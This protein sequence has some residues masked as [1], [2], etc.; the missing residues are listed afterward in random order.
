MA[1]WMVKRGL[2]FDCDDKTEIAG[3]KSVVRVYAQ[4]EIEQIIRTNLHTR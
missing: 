1:K 3:F 4:T 2:S